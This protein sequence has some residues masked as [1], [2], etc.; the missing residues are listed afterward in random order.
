M[1]LRLRTLLRA[2]IKG[3][4]KHI[5]KSYALQ[6]NPCRYSQF[7]SFRIRI[8]LSIHLY[9]ISKNLT[10][11]RIHLAGELFIIESPA[12]YRQDIADLSMS[13][14]CEPILV[15]GLTYIDRRRD[16]Y[17]YI[18]L[19]Y[20]GSPADQ[21]RSQHLPAEGHIQRRTGRREKRSP[22]ASLREGSR[23]AYAG[24]DLTAVA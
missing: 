3:K 20:I 2:Y 17:R 22:T 4:K 18:P 1:P 12:I 19:T 10:T 23:G 7:N 6:G 9:L 13:G 16:L 24:R 5:N 14:W 21:Y 11:S 15:S 8:F